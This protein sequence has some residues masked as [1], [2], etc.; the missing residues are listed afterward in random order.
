M[1]NAPRLPA[2]DRIPAQQTGKEAVVP[3]FLPGPC[4]IDVPED[5]HGGLVDHGECGEVPGVLACSFEDESEL[6]PESMWRM[7]S[8]GKRQGDISKLRHTFLIGRERSCCMIPNTGQPF[9]L[10]YH[11]FR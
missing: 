3:A 2:E 9:R 4:G 6:F 5:Q 1:A 7:V 10:Y 8:G 11:M